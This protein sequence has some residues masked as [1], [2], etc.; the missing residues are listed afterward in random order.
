[1]QF[2]AQ[3]QSLLEDQAFLLNSRG[4]IRLQGK[5]ATQALQPL[6]TTS[7]ENVRKKPVLAHVLDGDGFLMIDLF[8]VSHQG[9][10][11]IETDKSLIPKLLELLSSPCEALDVNARD[12]SVE[13]RVFAEL[14]DQHTFDDG[15]AFIK[16]VDPRWHMGAR[17]L[18]PA[19]GVI[20]SQWGSEIKWATHAL[21]LGFLPS[22]ARLGDIPVSPLEAGLH[23]MHLLD[24]SL[25]T[26]L[27]PQ[28]PQA[29]MSAP[30][31]NLSRRL[32]PMRIEPN[33]VS[34]PTMAG[35]V[36]VL[37][38]EM[39]IGRAICHHGLFALSLIELEPWRN[40]LAAG[41]PLHCA[42]QPVLVTWPS[43]LAQESRGRGGPVAM[44][45]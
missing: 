4:V 25:D 44:S 42:G 1:M 5:R 33:I 41:K 9:D 20:S 45:P 14:P 40:A 21:K 30:R 7:L 11:L 39:Q 13:W 3:Q 8:V 22:T 34:F 37:A 18:R 15:T 27:L 29:A 24:R 19:A 26:N 12:A 32:L 43:W 10:L 36:P 35:G 16:Y 28:G 38:G 31:E 23:A 6:V 2:A 17:L